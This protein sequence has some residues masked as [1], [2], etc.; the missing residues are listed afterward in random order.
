V[1]HFR[2]MEEL[3]QTQTFEEGYQKLSETLKAQLSQPEDARVKA[4]VDL[5]DSYRKCSLFC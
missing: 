2:I 4:K 5:K 1:E 3:H